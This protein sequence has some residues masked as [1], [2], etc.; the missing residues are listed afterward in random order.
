MKLIQKFSN[1]ELI[2]C[3]VWQY[4]PLGLLYQEF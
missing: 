3:A 1:K 4:A 2:Y